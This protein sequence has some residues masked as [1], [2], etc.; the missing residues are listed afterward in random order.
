M[1]PSKIVGLVFLTAVSAGFF[2]V[3]EISDGSNLGLECDQGKD[4][5]FNRRGAGG[6]IETDKDVVDGMTGIMADDDHFFVRAVRQ[7][8]LRRGKGG[9]GSR[10]QK[11]RA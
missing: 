4:C 5:G 3:K 9:W 8:L 11:D 6:G 7:L 2:L 10:A 1:E